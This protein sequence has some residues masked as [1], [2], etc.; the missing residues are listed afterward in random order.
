MGAGQEC[1]LGGQ[2]RDQEKKR[3]K[4]LMGTD[5]SVVISGW[6][7]VRGGRRWRRVKEDKW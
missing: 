6:G 1:V 4:K 3:E 2:W 7:A 5:N